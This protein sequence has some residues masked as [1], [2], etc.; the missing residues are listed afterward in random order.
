MI[1]VGRLLEDNDRVLGKL[2]ANIGLTGVLVLILA[3]AGSWWLAGLTLVPAQKA[4][5]QQQ[6]FVAN[7]S[8]ELRTPITLMRASTEVALRGARDP[9]QTELL[10]DVLKETDYMSVQ[11]DDLLLLSRLDGAP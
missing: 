1:Q 4:W 7:A 6:T 10:Q 2:A 5:D 8:H 11:V 3:G 9:K